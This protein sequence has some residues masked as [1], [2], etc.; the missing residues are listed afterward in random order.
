M[1]ED[2]EDVI[3]VL[4]AAIGDNHVLIDDFIRWTFTDLLKFR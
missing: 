3:K 4:K 1:S 2:R